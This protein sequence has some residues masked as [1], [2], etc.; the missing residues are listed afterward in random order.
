MCYISTPT[1]LRTF[2]GRFLFIYQGK[3][4][5]RLDSETLSFH[6]GW[7]VV[8]IPLP[9]IHTLAQGDYPFTAKPVALKYIEVSFAEHGVGRTLLFTP[10]RNK[11]LPVWETN[12]LVEEWLSALREAIRACTGHTL[13]VGR[14]HVEQEGFWTGQIKTFLLLAAIATVIFSLIP[15]VLEQRL[16][17][18]LIELLMG[19]ITAAAT[20][21]GLLALRC[22]RR[23][24]A[25]DRSG[26]LPNQRIE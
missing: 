15:L 6:S 7:Q 23:R 24:A 14:S 12:K 20:M 17:N 3:G 1:Y 22:W 21:V 25:V 26:T 4:E 2:R 9:A 10:V 19:P 5:L 18:R 8:T 13:S 11:L 16:P